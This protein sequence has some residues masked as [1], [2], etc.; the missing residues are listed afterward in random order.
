M[1]HIVDAV[2]IS[3]AL[4]IVHVLALASYNFQ[5]VRFVEELAW[6]SGKNQSEIIS[7]ASELVVRMWTVNH[8]QEAHSNA[9]NAE[10]AGF[11]SS[12]TLRTLWIGDLQLADP[13]INKMWEA[14]TFLLVSPALPNV[15]YWFDSAR[16]T[17]KNGERKWKKNWKT[18]P[19]YRFLILIVSLL[20]IFSKLLLCVGISTLFD[21]FHNNKHTRR[22]HR[23]QNTIEHSVR[24]RVDDSKW[25]CKIWNV[26]I[27]V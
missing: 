2:Q 21:F 17:I 4:F 15:L 5:R 6:F 20:V 11:D 7:Q 26:L 9:E 23:S 16:S 3:V 12:R 22:L 24:I 14:Y 18:H 1:R 8:R 19:M 25:K 13:I 10:S 27:E